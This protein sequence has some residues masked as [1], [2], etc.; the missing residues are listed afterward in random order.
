MHTIKDVAIL[1][2]SLIPPHYK[3]SCK[4]TGKKSGGG[5]GGEGRGG[6]GREAWSERYVDKWCKP[7]SM[8]GN[9]IQL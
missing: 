7:G 3:M 5:G 8:A 6:G 4:C 1:T 9:F 2:P